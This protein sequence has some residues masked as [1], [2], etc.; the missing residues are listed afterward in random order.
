MRAERVN[1]THLISWSVT[2]ESNVSHHEVERR[3]NKEIEFYTI[4]QSNGQR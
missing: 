1:N 3:M 2:R 4:R